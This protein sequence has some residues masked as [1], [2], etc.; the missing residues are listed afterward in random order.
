MGV[1]STNLGRVLRLLLAA[2]WLANPAAAASV[3]RASP[4][5]R[6]ASAFFAGLSPIEQASA[7]R[8]LQQ[9]SDVPARQ[10]TAGAPAV[11]AEIADAIARSEPDRL[12]QTQL[13][14][15][16]TRLFLLQVMRVDRHSPAAE[17]RLTEMYQNAFSRLSRETRIRVGHSMEKTA[18]LLLAE[19][20]QGPAAFDAAPAKTVDARG[21]AAADSSARL[22]R[23]AMLGRSYKVFNR[24]AEEVRAITVRNLREASPVIDQAARAPFAGAAE[25]ESFVIRLNALLNRDLPSVVPHSGTVGRGGDLRRYITHRERDEGRTIDEIPGRL[26]ELSEWL[27]KRLDDPSYDP[28]ALGAETHLRLSED[29]RPFHDGHGRT[30]RALIQFIL[31]RRGL[32]APVYSET[33][34]RVDTLHLHGAYI[35]A[36]QAGVRGLSRYIQDAVRSPRATSIRLGGNAPISARKAARARFER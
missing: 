29:I 20:R 32:P 1:Q 18:D 9:P 22:S 14:D 33:I 7:L 11:P 21:L 5:A 24:P 4:F 19:T 10:G 31:A 23:T 3:S 12:G 8:F 34:E 2:A 15:L 26:R 36:L 17:A 6:S 30:A 16:S 28:V 27:Y 25:L 35:T 13:E